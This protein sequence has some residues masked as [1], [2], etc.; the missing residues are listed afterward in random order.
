[1]KR[2]KAFTLIELLVVVAIITVL[3]S[4]LLPSLNNAR[5]LSK[6]AKCASSLRGLAMGN[7]AY[8]AEWGG[9]YIPNILADQATP[10]TKILWYTSNEM[11]S[12]TGISP[13][14]PADLNRWPLNFLCPN[15]LMS[16]SSA[17]SNGGTMGYSY[18]YNITSMTLDRGFSRYSGGNSWN[19]LYFQS[20]KVNVITNP[21]NSIQFADALDFQINTGNGTYYYI[22]NGWQEIRLTGQNGISAYRHNKGA[23]TA[24]FDNHVEWTGYQ[25]MM[26]NNPPGGILPTMTWTQQSANMKKWQ[27]TLD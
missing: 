15:A 26:S 10:A 22:V 20:I 17:N 1:M 2:C 24:F 9:W 12:V 3:I 21:G 11:R 5:E 18:G 7:S 25:N 14:S 16:I 13:A 4:I 27:C 6:R 23:N 19:E 8:A